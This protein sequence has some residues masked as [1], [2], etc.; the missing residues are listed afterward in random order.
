[1]F[2]N[3]GLN[4]LTQDSF[5]SE[6]DEEA[7][8]ESTGVPHTTG[9]KFDGGKKK[10]SINPEQ[11]KEKG[12]DDWDYRVTARRSVIHNCLDQG[13][14]R[15][16][17][18]DLVDLEWQVE[19]AHKQLQMARLQMKEQHDK[20]ELLEKKNE[21]NNKRIRGLKQKIGWDS[22]RIMIYEDQ[23]RQLENRLHPY[24]KND[25]EDSQMTWVPTSQCINPPHDQSWEVDIPSHSEEE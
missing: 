25:E 23:I 7:P 17:G 14:A 4:H 3:N 18:W 16:V 15:R 11:I 21:R 20:I 13:C 22:N 6:A 1:M 19:D 12:G 8:K 5:L 10:V 24:L 2:F 9:G